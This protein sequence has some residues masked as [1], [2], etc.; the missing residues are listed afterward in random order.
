MCN[1]RLQLEQLRASLPP[2]QARPCFVVGRRAANRTPLCRRNSPHRCG[3]SRSLPQRVSGPACRVNRLRH[4]FRQPG[5]PQLQPGAAHHL[6]RTRHRCSTST[7]RPGQSHYP[8]R[9]STFRQHRADRAAR[10][11]NHPGCICTS[12]RPPHSPYNLPQPQCNCGG[13]GSH[14]LCSWQN[15]PTGSA[16]RRAN[17]CHQRSRTGRIASRAGGGPMCCFFGIGWRLGRSYSAGNGDA[18]TFTANKRRRLRDVGNMLQAGWVE[19]MGI[20]CI[21]LRT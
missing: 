14:T 11:G 21:G 15:V 9:S 2:L 12:P 19:D 16:G 20:D 7:H 5:N 18:L 6:D 4:R 13:T 1:W 10:S 8:S 17:A 3:N